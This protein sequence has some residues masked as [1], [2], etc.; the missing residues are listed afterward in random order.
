M[1]ASVPLPV[2]D[3]PY[4]GP[5]FT[6]LIADSDRVAGAGTPADFYRW[7][8]QAPLAQQSHGLLALTAAEKQNW[9]V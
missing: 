1:A 9:P 3:Y 6:R 8:D 2:G 5:A 4:G 7:M